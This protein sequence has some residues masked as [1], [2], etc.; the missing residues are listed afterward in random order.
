MDFQRTLLFVALSII[1]LMLWQAWEAEQRP[2]PTTSQST[3]VPVA[4]SAPAATSAAAPSAAA[5]ESSQRIEVT[6]DLLHAVID[7]QGGDLRVLELRHYPLSLEAS[8]PPLRLLDDQGQDLFVAQSGLITTGDDPAAPRLMPYHKSRYRAEASR[9]TLADGQ[10]SVQ[11]RLTWDGPGGVQVAKVYTFRRDT[12]VVDLAYEIRNA[13][14]EA[15]DVYLYAQWLRRYVDQGV[16]LTTL[17]TYTGGVIY[18]T[19]KKYEKIKL[20]D[21]GSKPLVRDAAGGWAAMIQHYFVGAWLPGAE[22]RVQYFGDRRGPDLYALGY[23]TLEPLKL[24]AGATAGF[25]T[26]LYAGPK[27]QHRLEKVAEGLK[28]TVDYGWLTFIAAPLFWVLECLHKL[29]GN[30]GWS[31]I[32]LTILIKLAFHPLSVASYRSMAQMRKLQPR[33]Q[34][35][36][37]RYGADRQKLNEAMMEMYK[38]EKI[39]PLGGCL[40]ILIQI[41]VFI[42]LYWVLLESVELRQAPWALWIKDL[43]TKDPYYVLP[44]LMGGSMLV[45]QLLNPQ[46]LDDMQKKIM[47]VLPVVFTFM[48]LW[49]PAGLVLYWVVQNVL[50]IA[51]QWWINR[52]IVGTK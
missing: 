46:P 24:A 3:E 39:N 6:T 33:L 48:F 34:A 16:G 10:D 32:A 47:Y 36:K 21:L 28:L 4:P 29:L 23:K 2:A 18:T 27:E 13:G 45:Q 12:Y 37:E 17:P 8:S 5:L 42:A 1:V 52:Q 44:L 15:R 31:I 20:P 7:T 40:P 19:D 41:P 11:V 43:S 38:T 25:T 51:Q 50:S 14:R 30:W 26:R 49:F 22:E 9:Y 35:I